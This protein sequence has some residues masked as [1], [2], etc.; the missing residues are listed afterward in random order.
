MNYFLNHIQ[1]IQYFP[2]LLL[3][4]ALGPS[5]LYWNYKIL[6][7]KMRSWN[8]EVPV[9]GNESKNLTALTN[10]FVLSKCSKLWTQILPS[11]PFF[12]YEN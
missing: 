9:E 3:Y 12:S 1:Q 2:A 6:S 7:N 8:L 10:L 4:N 5:Y 11:T